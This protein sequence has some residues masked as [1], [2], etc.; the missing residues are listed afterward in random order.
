MKST[1]SYKV[2]II[3][4]N[5]SINETTR[6]YREAVSYMIDV[7]SKNWE[8]VKILSAKSKVN[9]VEKLIHSTSKNLAP[10]DFDNRFY[11]FPSYMRRSAISESIGIVSSYYSNLENYNKK[12]YEAIS[13]GK[14][15]KAKAPRLSLKHFS[16]PALYSGN[17]FE[18]LDNNRAKIKIYNG[19]D[20]VWITVNLRF[21]DLKYL[22]NLGL[23]LSSPVLEKR[24]RAYYLRF[25]VSTDVK[26][27]NPKLKEEKIVSVDLGINYSAVC[28]LMRFDGTVTKRLFINQRVEKDQQTHLINRLKLKQKTGGKY[29]KNSKLWAKINNL[30]KEISSKT[31]I[32]IIKFA[33]ENAADK[34]VLEY[35][36]FSGK[37]PKNIAQKVHLWAV[38]ELQAKIISKAHKEGIRINR[39]CARNTSILAF[40]GSGK[41][42]RNKSNAKL[43]IF[44][45]GKK[46]NTD[47]NASYNIGARYFI[48]QI[49]KTIS[50]KKWSAALAKVPELQRRTQCTLSSLIS[51][52]AVI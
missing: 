5:K 1:S 17:M 48:G 35:L 27:K 3:N 36:D 33:K 45:T 15:F 52:N 37:K 40:D 24:G 49:N 51:L 21:Q 25:S 9:Y 31:A 43:C 41:V 14:R 42:D 47:L 28:S 23:K 46:Y 12:R 22:N 26:L 2:K 4:V 6:I 29:A 32:E 18:M 11:K 38:K 13:N 10:Y 20:W 19:S 39:V 8:D 7:V 30:N 34:I 44:N 16:C 50:E